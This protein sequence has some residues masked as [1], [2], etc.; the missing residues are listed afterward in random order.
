MAEHTKYGFDPLLQRWVLRD[1]MLGINVKVYGD[2]PNDDAVVRIR[3]SPQK[4]AELLEFLR[5]IEW[6]DDLRFEHELGAGTPRVGEDGPPELTPMLTPREA[7]G[8]GEDAPSS[9]G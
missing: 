1:E 9:E 8:H 3:L 2:R 5:Q 4:H 7:I 6:H